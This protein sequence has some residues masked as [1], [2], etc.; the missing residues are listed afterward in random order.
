MNFS[1]NSTFTEFRYLANG[2]SDGSIAP[3]GGEE[4]GE[5]DVY[6]AAGT[7]Y[8]YHKGVIV[9]LIRKI[10]QILLKY[11]YIYS[12]NNNTINVV[13]NYNILIITYFHLL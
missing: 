5:R 9:I 8:I 10:I 13:N 12:R 11:I 3:P 4:N 6:A 1:V 7:I 2:G